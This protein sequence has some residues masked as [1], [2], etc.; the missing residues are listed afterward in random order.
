MNSETQKIFAEQIG[1]LPK[2]VVTFLSSTNWAQDLNEIGSLYNLNEEALSIFNREASLVLVGLTHP[3]EFRETLEQEAD[4][5]GAVLDAVV[6]SV[7][8]KI[9]APVRSALVSFI[10]NEGAEETEEEVEEE[11]P[12][13]EYAAPQEPVV[14]TKEPTIERPRAQAA[15]IAPDNLPVAEEVEPLI[16]PIPAKISPAPSSEPAHPFEEKMKKVF[17][18]G[19]QT[20]GEFTLEAPAPQTPKA[21]PIYH[22]DP[23]REPIE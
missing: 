15:D 18:A 20:M 13:I 1:L 16:P 3:D 4:L 23:Y 5:H 6:G 8:N 7:E 17:T 12:T 21:P 10:E 9:F 22:A 2:E 11:S 14:I 19:Q